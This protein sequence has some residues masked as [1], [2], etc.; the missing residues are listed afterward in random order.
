VLAKQEEEAIMETRR[1]SEFSLTVVVC[2]IVTGIIVVFYGCLLNGND[3]KYS[4]FDSTDCK[5]G[6][7]IL[8]VFDSQFCCDD[9]YHES[10]WVCVAAYDKVNAIWS[11]LLAWVIPLFPISLTMLLDFSNGQLQERK[12]IHLNRLLA[13]VALFAY[14]TVSVPIYRS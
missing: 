5:R 12:Y 8:E 7:F 11:S 2:T 6:V 10:D 14:R 1:T 9:K 3:H 13:Y 4:R